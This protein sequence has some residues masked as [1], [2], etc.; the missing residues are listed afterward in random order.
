MEGLART[1]KGSIERLCSASLW[2]TIISCPKITV[3]PL[4]LSIL[5]QAGCVLLPVQLRGVLRTSTRLPSFAQSR[6]VAAP[7][8]HGVKADHVD[9]AFGAEPSTSKWRILR[10][11]VAALTHRHLVGGFCA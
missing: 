11:V 7:P 6:H 2:C 8:L 4:Q 1:R 5:I 3:A 10:H 9:I